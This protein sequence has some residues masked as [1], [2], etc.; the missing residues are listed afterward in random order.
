MPLLELDLCNRAH[1]ASPQKVCLLSP[2]SRAIRSARQRTPV[3]EGM[4]MGLPS[5]S[6]PPMLLFGAAALLWTSE[7]SASVRSPTLAQTGLLEINYFI[8]QK[9]TQL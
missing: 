3:C 2:S 9:K 1:K 6:P 8:L 4:G 7:V 5:A